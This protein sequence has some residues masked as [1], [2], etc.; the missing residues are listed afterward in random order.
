MSIF[1]W[2]GL[3]MSTTQLDKKVVQDLIGSVLMAWSMSNWY[4][5]KLRSQRGVVL[6]SPWCL[7]YFD[8]IFLSLSWKNNVKKTLNRLLQDIYLDNSVWSY[9]EQTEKS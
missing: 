2:W 7:N 1:L 3:I 4:R 5:V 8:L 6:I 9:N